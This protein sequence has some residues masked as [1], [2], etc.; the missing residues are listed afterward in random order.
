VFLCALC[1]FLIL[2]FYRVVVLY[3]RNPGC[4]AMDAVDGMDF[5]DAA[6]GLGP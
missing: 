1:G 2:A 6:D 4:P 5:V 3:G